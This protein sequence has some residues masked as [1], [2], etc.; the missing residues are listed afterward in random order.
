LRRVAWEAHNHAILRALSFEDG[1]RVAAAYSA[2][3]NLALVLRAG[4]PRDALQQPREREW[5]ENNVLSDIERGVVVVGKLAGESEDAIRERVDVA[6]AR[7]ADGQP[8]EGNQ[9]ESAH[10]DVSE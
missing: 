5:L 1:H 6:R 3:D 10:S 8:F 4:A 9:G 7:R 2:L